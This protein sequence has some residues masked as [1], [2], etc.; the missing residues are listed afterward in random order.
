VSAERILVVDDEP[1]VRTALAAILKDE[2]FAVEL[3]ASGE[4][5]LSALEKMHFDAVLLDVWLPGIDGLATLKRLRERNLDA[6]VVMIS[7]HGTIETAVSATK[8]GA[9]D[10]VEKPLSLE[11][12][13][14]VLRNALR[15]RRLERM[16]LHLLEQL[17]RDTE[18]SGRSKAAEKLRRQVELAAGSDAP[19]LIWGEPGSGRDAVARRIHATGRRPESPFV[20]V[21]CGALEPQAAAAAL[22]GSA[23]Q[24]GRVALADGGS[25]FLEDVGRLPADLQRRLDASLAPKGATSEAPR[26]LASADPQAG[27]LDTGLRQRLEVLRIEVPSLRERR[28]DIAVLAERFMRELSREY[29]REPKG[30]TPESLA[31]LTAHDWPGNVRELHNL[32]EGLVLLAD[33]DSVDLSMLPQGMGGER[34]GLDDLY[35]DFDSLE[36]GVRAFERYHITRVMAEENADTT[37]AARRLGLSPQ[38]LR[39]RLDPS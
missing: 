21:P 32:V 23:D 33:A 22:F 19:V 38:E 10:F 39:A 31:A 12:T 13:L 11:K 27:R 18:I 37:A 25:L 8:L 20:D 16:N 24:K 6:E 2:G 15:Q 1:G 4:E 28:E 9:F 5:G 3:A 34:R 7:G 36:E 17:A 30:W 35:R 14:L 26:L 29:G